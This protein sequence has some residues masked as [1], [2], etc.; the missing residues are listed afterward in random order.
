[1]TT[2]KYQLYSLIVNAFVAV[3]TISAVVVALFRDR[4]KWFRPKLTVTLPDPEGELT[5]E[6]RKGDDGKEHPEKMRYYHLQVENK[7]LWSPA[8]NVSIHLVGIDERGL[9]RS[10][11]RK[12]T[13]NVQIQWRHIKHY[14][15]EKHTIGKPMEYDLCSVSGSGIRFY[16]IATASSFLRTLGKGRFVASLEVRSSEQET[17]LIPVDIAWDGVWCDKAMRTHFAVVLL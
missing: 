2:E 11:T 5:T 4:S 8:T 9:D 16:P 1:M 15:G 7:R 12:W 6:N 13:G 10:L 14:P 17:V 3:G